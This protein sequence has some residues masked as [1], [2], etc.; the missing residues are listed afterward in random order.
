MKATQPRAETFSH[1]V[2]DS[3]NVLHFALLYPQTIEL[4]TN[5]AIPREEDKNSTTSPKRR[6]NS[7]KK[8][9]GGTFLHL[10]SDFD[11]FRSSFPAIS[12]SSHSQDNRKLISTKFARK[13]GVER[14][15][16]HENVRY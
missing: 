13:N 1:A 14:F 16:K 2:A 4:N 6:L 11:P 5:N 12:T 3:V 9:F 10:S 7:Q 15:Q 8:R